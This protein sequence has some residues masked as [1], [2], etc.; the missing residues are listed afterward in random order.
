M[1]TKVN[2]TMMT[3]SH[4]AVK[5]FVGQI[6][7]M[8]TEEQLRPIFGE[9]GNVYEINIIKDKTSK[10]SRGCCFLTYMSRV[11]ADKAIQLFHNKRT[12][13]P[14]VNP[15]Q[16]K[17][18]DG[19]LERLEHKLFIG[20]LPRHVTESDIRNLFSRFGEIKDL[21]MLKASNQVSKGCAFLKYEMRESA[22]AAINALNG[23]H[24]M[25]G[26]NSALVVKWADTEK[27]KLARKAQ[28][29]A[30]SAAQAGQPGV[31]ATVPLGYG[32]SNNPGYTYPYSQVQTG[33]IGGLGTVQVPAV[34][35][36]PALATGL[37]GSSP[38]TVGAVGAVQPVG[39]VGGMQTVGGVP[40]APG[41]TAAAP[42]GPAG[43]G[44]M[45]ANYAQYAT[46]AQLATPYPGSLLGQAAMTSAMMPTANSTVVPSLAVAIANSIKP[47]MEG[48]PGANL[49]IYHIP[50]EFGD[51]DL[52][53][54]F[55]TFG[56]VISAKVFVDKNTGLSKCFGFVSYDSPDA[57][58][59]AIATMNGFQIGGRR[60]KVQLKR[61]KNQNKPY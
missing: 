7:K 14:M 50:P 57:A 28:K 27:E 31:F 42:M 58:Q 12:I 11:E 5:L 59:A 36:Q 32:I 60:L 16:V 1:D 39:P 26:G 56:N 29:L 61:D 22:Q 49:F 40:A 48:P 37:M 19:E 9:A 43:L 21:S 34:Q 13:P 2:G 53:T 52:N 10:M 46:A 41:T 18:A 24:K 44:P 20:M 55:S 6:P 54:A 45:G 51:H 38:T 8:L 23:I 17:Y 30:A 25:E 15:M 33:L 35:Q 47:Q 3:K 4:D